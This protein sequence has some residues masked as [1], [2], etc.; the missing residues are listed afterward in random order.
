MDDYQMTIDDMQHAELVAAQPG[1]S[2]YIDESGSFGFDFTKEGTSLYYV[3]CAVIVN[4]TNIPAIESKVDELRSTLF[5]GKEM[6]SSAIGSNHSR[7]AKVLTELLLLD[8]QLIVMIADKRKFYEDSPLTEYKSVFKKFLN[9]RLYDAMYLAY[10]KLKI[11]EDEYG[12]D[13]FQQGYR[14]YVQEH[15]PTSNIFDDYDFDYADSK[16]SNIV[17]IADIMAGSVMQHLLDSGAPD[18]LRIFQGRIADVVKFPDDYEIYKPSTKP[19]EHDNAIYQLACKC[20]TDYINENRN[21]EDEEIRLR[22][23]FLRLLLY[24][25]RMYSSSRYVHSGE[26]VQEL[27]RLTE[28]RVTKDFL[29]RRIIAPLRD[30]GV[31]IASSA[32]GYKIPTRAADIAT[33]VNQTASVVGP[34]LSRIEKCRSQIQKA[35]D[36]QLDI[37][38]D[39]ALTGYRRFFGDY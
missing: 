20:A 5:G 11:I 35:T 36:S 33:Y 30:D 25:V 38:D 6:K 16:N 8:F 39:P 28:K 12:T 17:Q 14:S 34:M 15:R 37:L 26:I 31:L 29:Y 24:N 23:L 19:T 7:R 3:V 13:E 32:H 1:R 21:S 9:Q 2:A 10:P 4:N 22:S 27:S 18:V